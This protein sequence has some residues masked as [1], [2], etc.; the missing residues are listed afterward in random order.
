MTKTVQ[1]KGF[2]VYQGVEWDYDKESLTVKM[3]PSRQY[4]RKKAWKAH[5]KTWKNYCPGCKKS[6]NLRA[7]GKG[8][9]KWAEEGEINCTSPHCDMDYDG[10]QGYEKINGSKKHLTEG[11]STSKSAITNSL[12]T[13][14]DTKKEYNA[15]K[16][17]KRNMTLKIP[18]LKGIK[19]GHC[20]QLSP[21]LVS[22]DLIVYVESV[23]ITEKEVVMKVNDKLEPPG[24]EYNP[25]SEKSSSNYNAT[26]KAEKEMVA[27][28]QDLKKASDL[29]TVKAIKAWIKKHITYKY[30][31]DWNGSGDPTKLDKSAFTKRW[32]SKSGNCVFMAW[33]FYVMAQGAGVTIEI[34]NGKATF[35]RLG[36]TGHLWNKYKGQIYDATGSPSNYQG[37]KIK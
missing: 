28:G 16:S 15:S 32:N 18:P 31:Y 19:D 34:W 22:K 6:G 35:S 3:F 27:Q 7:I 8:K 24:E 37:T 30:Y 12:N 5:K 29:E 17:A 4:P 33:L 14:D 21:P 20:H 25:P 9:G 23:E 10:V 1:Y 13:L 11:S 36:R 2:T 26:T